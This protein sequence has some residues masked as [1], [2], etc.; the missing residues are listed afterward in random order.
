LGLYK[1][2]LQLDPGNSAL[3]NNYERFVSFYESFKGRGEEKGPKTAPKDLHAPAADSGTPG[4]ARP[5]GPT[6]PVGIGREPPRGA[7][8]IPGIAP[9]GAEP[10][11]PSPPGPGVPGT[12]PPEPQPTPPPT[13]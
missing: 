2:A 7:P 9:P 5:H 6:P 10:P 11:G 1:Q 3:K 12:A 8:G 13:H 4:P